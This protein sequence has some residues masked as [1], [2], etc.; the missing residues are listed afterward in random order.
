MIGHYP[1]GA[2]PSS[3]RPPQAGGGRRECVGRPA[4]CQSSAPPTQ[5]RWGPLRFAG[6]ALQTAEVL[7]D[8]PFPISDCAGLAPR[9]PLP[10]GSSLPTSR[11]LAL[12]NGGLRLFSRSA[13]IESGDTS[14]HSTIFPVLER[15]V[16]LRAP[17]WKRGGLWSAARHRRFSVPAERGDRPK[18]HSTIFPVLERA[19]FLR[20]PAWK[21][22]GL[23]SAARHRRFRVPAERGDR[24]NAPFSRAPPQDVGTDQP[25]AER[26][27]G[28]EVAG[29]PWPPPERLRGEVVV[30]TPPRPPGTGAFRFPI[31]PC[32]R[33]GGEA[34]PWNPR[35]LRAL[36]LAL[37]LFR[38][39]SV[40]EAWLGCP[41]KVTPAQPPTKKPRKSQGARPLGM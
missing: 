31:R 5:G 2:D 20:A 3:L 13:G 41:L 12:E 34:P 6:R 27:C 29:F 38:F 37:P 15:A 17:A 19:V 24:P 22:G 4:S 11:R 33:R 26:G 7:P 10:R 14:P 40:A 36:P 35:P 16:V 25:L 1:R 9:L 32:G 21:R 8:F 30:G 18:P 39:R 23:W 28:G